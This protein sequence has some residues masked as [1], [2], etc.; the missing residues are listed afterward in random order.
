MGPW[1]GRYGVEDGVVSTLFD[2]DLLADDEEFA[3]REGH[4]E[5]EHDELDLLG[6]PLHEVREAAQSAAN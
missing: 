6:T 1:L 4:R 3:G 5:S 2:D